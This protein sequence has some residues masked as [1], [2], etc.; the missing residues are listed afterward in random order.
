VW[1]TC[2]IEFGRDGARGEGRGKAT[3]K[4]E[5]KRIDNGRPRHDLWD[6][7]KVDGE[8]WIKW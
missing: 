8:R 2:S 3:N 5:G 4:A 1:I 6:G 7:M